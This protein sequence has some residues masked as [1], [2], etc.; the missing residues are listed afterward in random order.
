MAF[1]GIGFLGGVGVELDVLLD[2]FNGAVGS[3]GNSLHRGSGEPVDDATA[4]YKAKEGIGVEE[5]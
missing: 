4:E 2:V 3:G 1:G 5:V